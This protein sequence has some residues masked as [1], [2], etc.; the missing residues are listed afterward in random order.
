MRSNR[1]HAKLKLSLEMNEWSRT[2]RPSQCVSLYSAEEILGASLL[3][4]MQHLGTRVQFYIIQRRFDYFQFTE[5]KGFGRFWNV[6]ISSRECIISDAWKCWK[7]V[8]MYWD[9]S[10][11]MTSCIIKSKQY[12]CVSVDIL[13][14]FSSCN[15]IEVSQWEINVKWC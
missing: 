11:F 4:S 7:A 3:H 10:L 8:I 2:H 5:F 14:M 13:S 1:N 9:N 6:L 12:H 15:E